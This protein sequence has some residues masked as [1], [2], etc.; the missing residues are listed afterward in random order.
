AET[1][2]LELETRHAGEFQVRG[3]GDALA[4]AI[5]VNRVQDRVEVRPAAAVEVLEA[6]EVDLDSL[7]LDAF[8]QVR[9]NAALALRLFEAD[10]PVGVGVGNGHRLKADV[11][12]DHFDQP[13]AV[14]VR[15]VAPLAA[16]LGHRRAGAAVAVRVVVTQAATVDVAARHHLAGA[17]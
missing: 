9:D 13:G 2:H 5:D 8:R 10:P 11:L 15:R 3:E 16:V 14:H 12:A 6:A 17:V 1:L 7:A 4:L